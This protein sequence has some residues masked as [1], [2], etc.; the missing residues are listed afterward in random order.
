M[1][2]QRRKD[3]SSPAFN[4]PYRPRSTLPRNHN[5]VIFHSKLPGFSRLSSPR[6]VGAFLHPKIYY[7]DI[8]CNTVQ[9][10]F[11]HNLVVETS[12]HVVLKTYGTGRVRVWVVSR[13]SD[14]KKRSVT[15]GKKK[16]RR[17]YLTA[18]ISISYQAQLCDDRAR[19]WSSDEKGNALLDS[20]KRNAGQ[21]KASSKP[22]EIPEGTLCRL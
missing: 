16:K 8:Y 17:S 13:E 10:A 3:L 9:G 19:S 15:K 7:S 14:R 11:G 1:V 20:K 5:E 22:L 21:E 12:N 6:S 4:T 18:P 2:A